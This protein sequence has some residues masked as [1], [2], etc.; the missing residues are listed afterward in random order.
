VRQSK[1]RD[2]AVVFSE[3]GKITSTNFRTTKTKMD[4]RISSLVW[5]MA[6]IVIGSVILASNLF[7]F[8][9][10]AETWWPV[11]FLIMTVVSF[12]RFVHDPAKNS[13]V[14]VP[15]GVFLVLFLIFQYCA[16]FGWDYMETLWPGFIAAP[17]VGMLFLYLARRDSSTLVSASV[18]IAISLFFFVFQGRYTQFWPV[19]LIIFG[20][21]IIL[22]NLRQ[23]KNAG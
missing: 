14:L 2:L 15:T 3:T 11:I 5:G 8:Q 20:V 19:V 18:L 17:G 12:S 21:I 6:F 9:V 13:G 22:R 4:R 16:L 10:D 23:E 7:D 1:N